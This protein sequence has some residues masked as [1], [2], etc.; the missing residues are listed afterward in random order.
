MPQILLQ[1]CLGPHYPIDLLTSNAAVVIRSRELLREMD[2][3]VPLSGSETPA[4]P[5]WSDFG[6]L[7]DR[8]LTDLNKNSCS[9]LEARS[10]FLDSVSDYE[11][12]NKVYTDG[13]KVVGSTSFAIWSPAEHFQF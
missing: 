2:V 6:P 7:V 13:S 4:I 12:Y 11:E 1:D 10:R 3:E 9:P 5:P 8:Q